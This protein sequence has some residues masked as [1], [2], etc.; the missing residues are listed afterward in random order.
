MKDVPVLWNKGQEVPGSSVRAPLKHS[1]KDAIFSC[2]QQKRLFEQISL[3]C[4][5]DAEI[6]LNE[7][8]F[9]PCQFSCL[10]S[11]SSSLKTSSLFS[12]PT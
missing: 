12:D 2:L 5:D 1:L 8:S 11:S 4:N 6:S 9:L 10:S 7:S 3:K